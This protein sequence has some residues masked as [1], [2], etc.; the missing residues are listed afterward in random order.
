MAFTPSEAGM[1]QGIMRA[2]GLG[3]NR[4]EPCTAPVDRYL[5]RCGPAEEADLLPA[6]A[7]EPA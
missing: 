1:R 5:G 6:H 2:W 4:I 7:P 3:V